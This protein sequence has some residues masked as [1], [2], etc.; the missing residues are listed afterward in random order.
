[1]NDCIDFS[2]VVP[3]PQMKG[4]SDADTELLKVM[5]TEA[6]AVIEAFD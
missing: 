6:K 1:M 5:A 2:S 4:D 3:L